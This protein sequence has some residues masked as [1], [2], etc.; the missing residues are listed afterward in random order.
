M[1]DSLIK[2]NIQE[3]RR[4]CR[5]LQVDF[6]AKQFLLLLVMRLLRQDNKNNRILLEK[7]AVSRQTHY[8][9]LWVKDTVD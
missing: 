1:T 9:K 2:K 6:Q 7:G 3:K 5:I 4:K 8:K